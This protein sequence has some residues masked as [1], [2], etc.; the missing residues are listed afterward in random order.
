MPASTVGYGVA[1]GELVG[2]GVSEG[3]CVA[4]GVLV[5]VGVF[6]GGSRGAVGVSVRVEL[7]VGCVVEVS[8]ALVLGTVVVREQASAASPNARIEMAHG[9]CFCIAGCFYSLS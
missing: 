1:V 5:G 6:V 7:A 8:V 9:I 4:G 3:V 2:V